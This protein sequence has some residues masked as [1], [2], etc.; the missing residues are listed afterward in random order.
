M[1]TTNAA[2]SDKYNLIISNMPI[3]STRTTKLDFEVFHSYVKSIILPDYSVEVQDSSYGNVIQKNVVQKS[4]A[5]LGQ[6]TVEFVVDEDFENYKAF[7]DWITL[8]RDGCPAAGKTSLIDSDIF[9]I[10]VN[11]LDNE[12]RKTNT[13]IFR[14]CILISLSSLTVAF[15]SSDELVFS[16]TFVFDTFDIEK[17]TLVLNN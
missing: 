10:R 7:F 11:V 9:Q 12:N 2:N 15:G 4:N 16:T 5:D 6:M 17:S 8:L 3:P 13:L 1:S 14:K